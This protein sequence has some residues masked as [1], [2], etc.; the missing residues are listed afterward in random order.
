MRPLQPRFYIETFGCQMN[1]HDSEKLAGML[2]QMDYSKTEDVNSADLIIMNTC[3]VREH[4][5][6]KVFGHLGALL[7]LK[8]EKPELVIAVCGCMMQQKDVAL[9]VRKRFPFVDIIFGT[10][11]LHRFPAMLLRV[12]ENRIHVFEVYDEDGGI[13]EGVPVSRAGGAQA[14]VTIMYGCN[15]FCSYCIVP[16]VRGRER[17]RAAGDILREAGEV[18]ATGVKEITVLGQ[19]VNAYGKDLGESY[20]FADL[21]LDIARIDGLERIR[22]MTSHPK[23]VSSELIRAMADCPKICKHIHLPV[24]SGSTRILKAMNRRYTREDYLE[25]ARRL[26]EAVNGLEITTD[27]IVGFPGET[28][29]DF[30]DTLDLVRRVG[31]CAA[32]TFMYSPRMGTPAATME[33]Q[34]QKTVKKERL[35]AL[36]ALVTDMIIAQNQAYIGRIERVL[37]EGIRTTDNGGKLAYGRTHASKMVYFE[38]DAVP[39]DFADV[40]ITHARE[41]SLYGQQI[42]A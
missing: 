15:N 21:L 6:S 37:T 9:R 12:L 19:N 27:I 42:K 17:S 13:V 1:V 7:A 41:V 3:C 8:Q 29:E 11:N 36:N 38:G 33:D 25:L 22:F 18:A 28:Q 35:L 34:I 16:Y 40:E 14:F 32:Y 10:H 20:G 2:E 26:K 24:Q 31:F 30:E 23:D 4:A 39:G 5:E